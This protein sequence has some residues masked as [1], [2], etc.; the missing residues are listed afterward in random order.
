MKFGAVTH[1]VGHEMSFEKTLAT[2][3]KLGF[4]SVLLLTSRGGETVRADGT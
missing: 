3:K 4:D 1:A 2:I